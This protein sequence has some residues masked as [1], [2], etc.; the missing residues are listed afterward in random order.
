MSINQTVCLLI[1]VGMISHQWL[2]VYVCIFVIEPCA[3]VCACVCLFV[4]VYRFS[5]PR[6][7]YSILNSC[8]RW[9]LWGRWMWFSAK[10]SSSQCTQ[11]CPKA[12]RAHT[13]THTETACLTATGLHWTM[14]HYRGLIESVLHGTHKTGCVPSCEC[15]HTHCRTPICL[16]ALRDDNRDPHPEGNPF[17]MM[18][19]I[20][21]GL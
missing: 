17:A 15:L 6:C 5:S 11:P 10:L 1:W 2:F 14:Q 16:S 21:K 3:N 8:L 12:P 19:L 9:W 20:S 4:Y 18:K 13:H 7:T